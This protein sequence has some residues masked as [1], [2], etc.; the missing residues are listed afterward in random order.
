M[1]FSLV[2]IPVP[3]EDCQRGRPPRRPK[4]PKA[5]FINDLRLLPAGGMLHRI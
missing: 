4:V 3:L 2:S 5:K 1:K